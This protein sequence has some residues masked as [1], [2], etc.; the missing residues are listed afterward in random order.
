MADRYRAYFQKMGKATLTVLNL[1][2]ETTFGTWNV[3]AE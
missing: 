3:L 2:L 1:H